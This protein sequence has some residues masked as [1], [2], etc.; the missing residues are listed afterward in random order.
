[1]N[2]HDLFTSPI[3]KV[4]TNYL[5]I[6]IVTQLPGGLFR[7]YKYMWNVKQNFE[8][9]G[10]RALLD[11]PFI[12]IPFSILMW[13]I[14]FLRRGFKFVHLFLMFWGLF[15]AFIL[16]HFIHSIL[17]AIGLIIVTIL[18]PIFLL[19]PFRR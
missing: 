10:I 18:L 4:I 1:M 19:N 6:G 3:S 12:W 9:Y 17:L 2:I 5:L 11:L 7:R 14:P 8:L 15:S 16:T 13:P